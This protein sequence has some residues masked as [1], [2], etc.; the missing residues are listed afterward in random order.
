VSRLLAAAAL[1]LGLLASGAPAANACAW[2]YCP[3][4][5]IVCAELGCPLYCT[6]V[7]PPVVRGCIL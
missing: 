4:T 7:R 3:G 6:P 5:S 2:Q 1:G